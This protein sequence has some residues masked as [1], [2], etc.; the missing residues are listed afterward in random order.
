VKLAT[1]DSM[2]SGAIK[3]LEVAEEAACES[4]SA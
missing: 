1:L 2:P 4:C 3:G